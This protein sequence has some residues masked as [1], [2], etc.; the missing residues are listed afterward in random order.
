MKMAYLSYP[1][2]DNPPVRIAEVTRIAHKIMEK[3]KDI[4]LI[5]P[6]LAIDSMIEPFIK[7]KDYLF[8]AVWELELIKRCDILILGCPLDYG[9]SPGMVWEWAYAKLLGKEIV[10]A[11]ELMK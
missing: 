9:L 6:H 8:V 2:T 4:V 7:N 1:Y 10:E 5:V 11:K 3:H